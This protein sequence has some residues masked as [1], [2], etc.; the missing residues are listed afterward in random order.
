MKKIVATA[1]ICAMMFSLAACSGKQPETTITESSETTTHVTE[2]TEETTETTTE[3]TTL[4]AP[5]TQIL[6]IT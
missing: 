3:E 6:R 4:R 5:S 2:T 1:L